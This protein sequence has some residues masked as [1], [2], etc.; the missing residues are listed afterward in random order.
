[1][2]AKLA[3]ELMEK[4]VSTP[5]DE[6]VTTYDGYAEA[7]GQ[8]KDAGGAVY[9]DSNYLGFSRNSSCEYAVVPQESPTAPAKFI[10]A[11]VRV[12]YRGGEIAIISRLISK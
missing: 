7:Q 9:T 5:F 3:G 8:V 4:I 10:R 1:L 12:Y 6:I 2:G 11:T